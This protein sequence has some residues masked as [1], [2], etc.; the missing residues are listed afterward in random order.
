MEEILAKVVSVFGPLGIGWLLAW[1]FLRV[2]HA[3]QDK[4]MA[5]FIADT[6]AKAD[7]KNALDALTAAVKGH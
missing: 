4:V 5:A 3:L 2:N 6:Q 1:Y 7:M